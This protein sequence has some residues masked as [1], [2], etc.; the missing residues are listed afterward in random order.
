MADKF[1]SMRDYFA[2]GGTRSYQFRLSQLKILENLLQKEKSKIVEAL[3]KDLGKPEV[4][5]LMAEWAFTMEEIHFA[6]K[7]LR[8]WMKKRYK[9]IPLKLWPARSYV[10]CEPLGLVLVMSPWNYPF[11]LLISPVI[12]AIA[13]GNCVVLKPSELAA[14]TAQLVAKVIPQYFDSRYI[15]VV[16]GG[17]SETTELLKHRFDHIFFTGSGPVGSVVAQ[18]AA[19]HLTPVTLE[20]GG[21]SPTIVCAD[22]DLRVAA[23]RLVW[24]KFYNAGQTCVAPDY[25][26]IEGSIYDKFKSLITLEIKE[27]FGQEPFQSTAYGRIINKRNLQRLERMID[28]S[29]VIYGGDVRESDLYI[30]PTV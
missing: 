2:S 24:G 23:R 25:V 28:K 12:G 30:A 21:K 26:Y 5:S 27:Q 29:K 13:A 22:A 9:A 3:R 4:E 1:Q 20:L 7:E 8:S 10:Q 18:A 15:Q 17:V 16:E 11:Q 14:H 19:R 6:K